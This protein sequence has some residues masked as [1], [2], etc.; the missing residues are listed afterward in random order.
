[1]IKKTIITLIFSL[2][3][4][5]SVFADVYV[6]PYNKSDGSHV[7][8]HYRSSPDS[9]TS[10]NWGTKGNTNPYTGKPG[11]NNSSRY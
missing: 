5:N 4:F 8:G 6:R 3:F 7:E 9:T 10:N 11:T 1:M 2:F